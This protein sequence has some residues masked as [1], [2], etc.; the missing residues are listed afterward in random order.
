MSFIG[1]VDIFGK[2]IYHSTN[3]DLQQLQIKLIKYL[4]FSTSV[5]A[6]SRFLVELNADLES[7]T[8]AK[9][10]KRPQNEF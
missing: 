7:V 8:H 4:Y 6:S 5:L 10:F 9:C 1:S 3:F 2:N